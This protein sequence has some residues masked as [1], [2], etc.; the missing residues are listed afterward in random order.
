LQRKRKD[1]FFKTK[2]LPGAAFY[3]AAEYAIVAA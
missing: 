2:D 3:M 1:I